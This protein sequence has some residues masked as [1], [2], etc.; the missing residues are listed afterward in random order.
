LSLSLSFLFFSMIPRP[1]R[2][3]LFPY[4]TLFRSQSLPRGSAFQDQARPAGPARRVDRRDRVSRLRCLLADDWSS[5]R[6]RRRLDGG[7][8]PPR[9][10]THLDRIDW[11]FAAQ[12]ARDIGGTFGLQLVERLD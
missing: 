2:S 11:C 10:S 4:T 8:A 12:H 7:I 5:P 1:P 9:R 6:P 3:T